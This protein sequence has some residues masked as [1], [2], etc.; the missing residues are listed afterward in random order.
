MNTITYILLIANLIL[1][2]TN[3]IAYGIGTYKVMKARVDGIHKPTQRVILFEFLIVVVVTVVYALVFRTILFD[4]EHTT[5]ALQWLNVGLF[6]FN[7]GF[8]INALLLALIVER[9][10]KN[11]HNSKTRS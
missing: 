8:N 10:Q 11:E 6:L 9:Q 4:K 7:L 2:I 1:S 5:Q 3:V